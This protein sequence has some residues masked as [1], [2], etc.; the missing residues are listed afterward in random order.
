MGEEV[1]GQGVARAA[2]SGRARRVIS[3][4]AAARAGGGVAAQEGGRDAVAGA[5]GGGQGFE[6]AV[7]DNGGEGRRVTGQRADLGEP[8]VV[9]GAPSG[10]QRTAPGDRSGTAPYRAAQPRATDHRRAASP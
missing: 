2:A 10:S 9:G 4:A 1:A 8:E 3:R 5:Q 6:M 7:Q